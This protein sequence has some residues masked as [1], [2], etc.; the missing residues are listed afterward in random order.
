MKIFFWKKKGKLKSLRPSEH[1]LWKLIINYRNLCSLGCDVIDLP[2]LFFLKKKSSGVG[3][4][5]SFSGRELVHPSHGWV[6]PFLCCSLHFVAFHFKVCL[7]VTLD[8]P[9]AATELAFPPFLGLSFLFVIGPSISG[10]EVGLSFFG[11]GLALR[12]REFGPS[13]IDF[14]CISLHFFH[15]L[16]VAVPSQGE[17]SLLK[18]GLARPSRGGGWP[19]LLVV[20][21]G[22]PFFVG[23]GGG[24]WPFLPSRGVGIGPSF[25]RRGVG[26]SFLKMWL[27]NYSRGWVWPFLSWFPCRFIAFHC[28]SLQIMFMGYMG[29]S[30]TILM[31]LI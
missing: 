6:W 25:L 14:R 20:W 29:F 5:P 28:M 8:F 11:L 13:F 15:F 18:F 10:V 16:D 31:S 26:P 30:K 7:W 17:G 24:G 4:V 9:N 1:N 21:A 3:F 27:A 23:G 19:C 22:S 12:G 2:F